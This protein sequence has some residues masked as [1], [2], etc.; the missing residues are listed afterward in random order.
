[1]AK[2]EFSRVGLND[3]QQFFSIPAAQPNQ[4]FCLSQYAMLKSFLGT[5]ERTLLA[6]E[7]DAVFQNWDHL[8]DAIAELPEDWDVLYLGANITDMVFGIKEFPPLKYSRYLYRVRKAWTTHAVAYS[9]RIVETIVRSYPVHEFNMFDNWLNESILP[10]HKC[11]LVNPMI[12]WQR[13]GK[14]DLWGTETDYTG[15]FQE[16]NKIMCA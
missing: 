2:E 1:M 13:P 8:P 11:F 3:V 14:S 16:G 12:C 4:S 15:A 5:D 7:D 10:H 6:L 9:R